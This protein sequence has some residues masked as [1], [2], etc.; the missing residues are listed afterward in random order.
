[1]VRDVIADEIQVRQHAQET[2]NRAA[3]VSRSA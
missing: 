1:M 2:K 3:K